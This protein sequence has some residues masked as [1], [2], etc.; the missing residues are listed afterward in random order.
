MLNGV[1]SG[2]R[3]TL[4]GLTRSPGFS[5]FVVLTFALGIGSSTAIFSVADAFLFKPLPFPQPGRLVM[6]HER[7]PGNTSL[8]S[9]VAPADFLDFQSRATSYETL[10]AYEQV[11]FN[12]SQS[13]DPETVY[14]SIVTPNF[15]D[16]LGAKPIL[17]RTFAA[18]EDL[19][20]KNQV[21]VLSFG[22]WQ[23]LFAGDPN[24]VGRQIEL[25]GSAFSVIGVMG[26]SIRFPAGGELWAPLTLSPR[27]RQDRE[28]HTLRVLGRLKNG[29]SE[30]Q[31][32]AELQTIAASLARNF[33]KTN[34]GW[35]I[36]I[37]PL[38]RY[39]LG[40]FNRE[41]TLLLLGAVFFVLLIVCAN[42]M[43]LQFARI[44]GRQKEFGV[45]SAL[46]ASRW[47]IARAILAESLVLSLA[48]GLASLFFS[49]WSLS[50]ILSSMPSDVA[51]YIAGWDEI[52]LDARTLTFTLA[53]AV[54]A[55]VFSGLIPA[56][57]IRPDVNDALKE[58][59]R[60]SSAGPSR[61]R[62]R[63]VLV[64]AQISAAMVLV[65]GAGLM[66]KGSRSLI[67]VNQGLHPE[68]VLTMQ[69]SLSDRHYGEESQR[70]AFWDRVL[71]RIGALPG[72]QAATLV[73]NPPYGTNE[74]LL[75]YTVEGQ[76]A[77]NVGERKSAQVMSVS[78]NYLE[79]FAIPLLAGR[80]F[81]D[82][83]GPKAEGV[84]IVSENFARRNWPRADAIGRHVRLGMHGD[85]LT[86]IGV[87]K[88]VRYDPWVKEIAP[89]IYQPYRQSAL[90][91][92]YVAVRAKGDPLALAAPA[93]RAILA[94][95]I[96][97]P[98]W[99]IKTLDRVIAEQLIG[100]SY[101][102]V[103]LA[104]LGAIAIL[105]SAAGIYGLMAY[106]VAERTR[107]IGIRLALGAERQ[108]VLRMLARR[109]VFLTL[110]G[111]VIGL[112][113][114]IPLARVLSSLIFGVSA[115]DA[116]AFG[117]TA[118]LLAAVALLACYIPARRAMKVDPM[119][120]LR[121]E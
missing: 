67:T 52:Q 47:G 39:I 10:A 6:L 113:I 80:E 109:G 106:T 81:R 120:A 87:V 119:V 85:W 83:D 97:R 99:E 4:R 45:R 116:T 107:E 104:V 101:V 66:L 73:S 15:F 76:P 59:A 98:M 21:A 96:D 28:N 34:Q 11:D 32:R 88:D 69:I 62:S 38:N 49:N 56:L 90:Y 53:V 121:Q 68:S 65:A 42:V 7:A 60:G 61:L 18:G 78:P 48:G 57:R 22:L 35:G 40:D 63:S 117:A 13:G 74:R 54:L 20:G 51:K 79:T 1:F 89:A 77:T 115:G 46:G 16:T 70:V 2:L 112:A 58:G 105:L 25:N 19:A 92:T 12:V 102:A 17:G 3:P 41:Y 111:L 118:F 64:I 91:Y 100:L 84:V 44:S 55:G 94:L 75:P 33:P 37:Q 27:D 110:A 36:L 82:S 30:S 5:L 86:V 29:V 93:R 72:V 71:D 114:S 9:A 8:T 23:R 14:S 43:S 95:D 31:A 103:M 24:I 50:L 108:D 26:K